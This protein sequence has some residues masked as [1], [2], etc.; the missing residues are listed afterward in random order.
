MKRDKP[1]GVKF[2]KEKDIFFPNHPEPTLRWI[3]QE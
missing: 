3:Q 1:V 2:Q